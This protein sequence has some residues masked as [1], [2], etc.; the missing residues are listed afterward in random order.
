V[1]PKLLSN[2][3]KAQKVMEAYIKMKKFDIQALENA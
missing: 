2:P 3:D 1:L